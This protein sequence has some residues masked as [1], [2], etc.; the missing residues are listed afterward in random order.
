[1]IKLWF[2]FSLALGAAALSLV[3]ACNSLIGNDEAHLAADAAGSGGDTADGG[4][5]ASAGMTAV[6][7]KSSGGTAGGGTTSGGTH[8][9]GTTSGGTTSGGSTGRGGTGGTGPSCVPPN[10]TCTTTANCCQSGPNIPTAY[11][12]TCLSDDHL[13]H[14]DCNL[15]D[16]CMSFCCID[17]SPQQVYGVCAAAINCQ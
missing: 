3:P 13:C 8:S 4:D 5:T 6:S 12:A 17:L 10:G 14:A 2:A 9:G 16:D 15:D 11:G 7:G 1:M